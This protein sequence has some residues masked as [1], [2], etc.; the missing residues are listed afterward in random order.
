M[1]A[2]QENVI[3]RE[4]L[5]FRVAGGLLYHDDGELSDASEWPHIDFK[6]DSALEIELKLRERG[7]RSLLESPQDH[8]RPNPQ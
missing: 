1:T 7:I 4:L 5:A 6:R 2:E 8:G 3:L